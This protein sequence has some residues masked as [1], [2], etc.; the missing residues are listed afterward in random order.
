M[1]KF[2]K[3][4]FD[5]NVVAD[6]SNMNPSFKPFPNKNRLDKTDLE[7]VYSGINKTFNEDFTLEPL[8]WDLP[9]EWKKIDYLTILAEESNPNFYIKLESK[10]APSIGINRF[11]HLPF[12][13]GISKFYLSNPNQSPLNVKIIYVSNDTTSDRVNNSLYKK[14]DSLLFWHIKHN[15]G[16][17]PVY[18]FLDNLGNPTEPEYDLE[19]YDENEILFSF[20]EP[21]TGYVFL[22][23]YY[24]FE[25][26]TYANV[27][28]LE[29]NLDKY[30]SIV[31]FDT[32]GGVLTNYT[33]TYDSP[34]QI[35]L[36]FNN[37]QAGRALAY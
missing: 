37:N 9:F 12:N 1:S 27:W 35:T 29:H 26:P 32:F 19:I 2:L 30:P 7:L 20:T 25:Q 31:A 36:T 3:I 17:K 4:G 15:L 10:T 23:Y 28:V 21:Y 13:K 5:Y 16:I 18:T 6:L 34:D 8:T 22:D 14:T 11:L 33:V 24:S